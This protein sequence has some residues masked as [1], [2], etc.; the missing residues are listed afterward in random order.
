[1]VGMGVATKPKAPKDEGSARARAPADLRSV[2]E[3]GEVTPEAS[4]A[5]ASDVAR[6]A[7]RSFASVRALAA[8]VSP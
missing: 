5:R 1:M 2:A 3:G 4:D 8:A 7:P 6:C